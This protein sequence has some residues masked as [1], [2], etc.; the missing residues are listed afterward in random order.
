MAHYIPSA[1][2]VHP[3]ISA[4]ERT[5]DTLTSRAGLL[6]FARYIDK[7]GLARFTD[8]W[9]TDVR[10]SSKG[11]SASECLRQILLFFIDG[12][13]RHL[14]RFDDLKQDPGYAATIERRPEDLISSHAVKRFIGNFSFGRIWLLRKLL[15]E[16]FIWRLCLEKPKVIILDLDVMVLDN[17]EAPKREGVQPTYKKVKG[18][19]PLQMVYNRTIVDAVLRAGHHHSNHKDSTGKMVAYMVNLIRRRYDKNVPIVIRQDTGYFDQKLFRLY[20]KIDVGYL[21][22]GKLYKDIKQYAERCP[23]G[24]WGTHRNKQQEW[25]YLEFGDKRGSWKRLRRALFCRPVYED[26]QRLL[27]FARP[28]T[29]IYTN[30]GTGDKIDDLLRDAGYGNLL[31]VASLIG[32]YHGRGFDELVHRALKDFMA[33]QLPFKGFRQNTV[34]Y[35]TALIAFALFEAFKVDVCNSV[36]PVTAYPTTLRRSLI[37]VAGKIVSHSGRIVMKVTSAI[38]TR[39]RFD[40]LWDKCTSPPPIPLLPNFDS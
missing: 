36:I 14:T 10:K 24:Q 5:S 38:M 37:D 19:A 33:E 8:R 32:C 23:A 31:D 16:I 15:Q 4:V 12:T 25:S 9:F 28:D 17:D 39:L 1:A 18:F 6:L 30:I 35:Y 11:A 26:R 20:E 29:L 3:K 21:C 27:E 7:I 40:K 22:G 2:K 13:S 34:F